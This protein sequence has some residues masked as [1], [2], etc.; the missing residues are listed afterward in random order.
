MAAPFPP[1]PLPQGITES[2]LPSHD[3]TYHVLS[4]G[5]PTKPL[6]LCL[7]GFPELAYSWRK[8][9]PAIANEGYHVV[10]Y[11]QRGYGRTT[12]WDNREFS[13]VDLNTFGFTRLVRD[14]VI[15]LN[16]LGYKEVA[17]VIGHDFGA[18][19]ASM[20]ALMRP[21][22]FKSV[23]T[24]SHPFKGSPTL[25]FNTVPNPPKPEAKEDVH[26]ALAELP[27]PRKHYK[28]YYST[29][30]A[31]EE[32]DN[33]KEGLHEF[34][35][36]YFHLKSADWKGNDPKPLK[37]WEANELA[38]LPYYYV[39][40]LDAGMRKS[41]QIPMADED[42]SSVSKASSRWLPDDELAIY[43]QEWGRNGFQGGLNWYRI[44]TDTENMKDVELFAGKKI[45]VPALF[46][47]G[48]QDWGTYQEPGAVEKLSEVCS[49]SRGVELVD[50]AGHWVQ[51]E[52]P[53]KVIELVTKFLKDVK[54]DSISQ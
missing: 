22:I 9:M 54:V 38:K 26:K 23:I 52:Q 18:V 2:Y 36:G 20:C 6:V 12:G 19:G 53:E 40:P 7:H 41:I 11:D 13:S 47:S 17:C 43:V 8:I 3:L 35:R 51:Q 27:Q 33:P 14:A 32:M 30:P 42:P 45:D 1:L 25:P 39:M 29:K 15:F 49:Q 4:A 44:A 37:A 46:I 48:K 24:M 28:W 10:G 31:A 16:A 50:G 21:D 5:Q 34:L